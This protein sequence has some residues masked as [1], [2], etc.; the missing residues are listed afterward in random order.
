MSTQPKPYGWQPGPLDEKAARIT[1]YYQ[2]TPGSDLR[3]NLTAAEIVRLVQAGEGRLWVDVDC[4]HTTEWLALAQTIGFHPLIVEDTLSPESRVKLEEYESYLFVVARD[5]S[6]NA[7]TPDPYDF[8][9]CNIYFFLGSSYLI[10]V[11][12]QPSRATATLAERIDNG[13]EIMDR[14]VDYL[15]YAVLDA[16]V[17]L[18]FPMLDEVDEF[19][20]DLETRI[21][22]SNNQ[23]ETLARVFDLKRTLASLRKQQAPMR[24]VL[25]TLAN[26]PSPYLVP[27][28]QVYFR[29]VYDH[30]VRQV[31][32]IETFRDLLTGALE[33][34]FSVASSRMNE[35]M[36]ALTIVGTFLLPATWIASIYGM[37][38]DR[39]PFLDSPAGFWIAVGLMFGVS[40]GLLAYLKRKRWV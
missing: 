1:S 26:R 18:Y 31:E 29:D 11:H 37:N 40:F 2:A 20:D 38:F 15:M 21:F 7:R 39:M 27:A 36:K 6:F 25:A 24:E 10:T 8:E 9:T 34:H 19:I 12:A 23:K 35:I 22:E 5:A 13:P 4:Q 33:I 17:D 32:S 30:I 16:M 14:G 3:S 28:T